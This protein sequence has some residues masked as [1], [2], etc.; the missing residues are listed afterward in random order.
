MEAPAP[1]V[2]LN[3]ANS[4]TQ[5][6]QQPVARVT[7]DLPIADLTP[8]TPEVGSSSHATGPQKVSFVNLKDHSLIGQEHRL[9]WATAS[10]SSNADESPPL[11]P[12]PLSPSQG[13]T[14]SFHSLHS[15]QATPSSLTILRGERLPSNWSV[16]ESARPDAEV[17]HSGSGVGSQELYIRR[18]LQFF[19][20]H[21]IFL[22]ALQIIAQLTVLILDMLDLVHVI[23][24][25]RAAKASL[26]LADLIVT[27]MLVVEIASQIFVVGGIVRYVCS[28]SRRYSHIFDVLVALLSLVLI[29]YDVVLFNDGEGT[30]EEEE[31]GVLLTVDMVRYAL[32]TVR[33]FVFLRRL[34][35]LLTAPLDHLSVLSDDVEHRNVDLI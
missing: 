2:E 18:S 8:V 1:A 17:A 6:E 22:Y 28:K 5:N 12:T 14:T 32:R 7:L 21:F 35:G 9:D 34:Y 4:D 3:C 27:I 30:L 26:I 25:S 20:L 29:A 31:H 15:Q 16:L 13:V 24:L 11:S 19:V 23:S 10:H 33:L